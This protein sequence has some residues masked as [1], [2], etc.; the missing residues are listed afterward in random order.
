MINIRKEKKVLSLKLYVPFHNKHRSKAITSFMINSL[1]QISVTIHKL[2]PPN[3][4]QKKLHIF[5]TRNSFDNW[6]GVLLITT[7]RFVTSIARYC[8]LTRLITVTHIIIFIVEVGGTFTFLHSSTFVD[9][10]YSIFQSYNPE[11]EQNLGDRVKIS[12]S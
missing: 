9:I 8:H 4:E 7:E 5:I 3:V 11:S 12:Q 6:G 10:S 2:R 1:H